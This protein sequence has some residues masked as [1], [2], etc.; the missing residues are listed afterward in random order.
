MAALAPNS[1]CFFPQCTGLTCC[2]RAFLTSF[3]FPSFCS[4]KR[5]VSPLLTGGPTS[6]GQL[7]KFENIMSSVLGGGG[8]APNGL[9]PGVKPTPTTTA[10]TAAMVV[11]AAAA[12]VAGV[13]A[14]HPIGIS[15]VSSTNG[16]C[17]ASPLGGEQPIGGV[18]SPQQPSELDD[19]VPTITKETSPGSL[20]QW[21]AV[22][23]LSAYTKTFAQF[24]GS[25]LLR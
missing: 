13:Q 20:A 24:S 10:A 1:K 19:Y 8:V 6:P 17:K 3:F 25:D 15:N 16:L 18:L 22:H 14:N 7:N 12:A 9:S 2:V 23:R 21:L 4:I 11:A 5:N